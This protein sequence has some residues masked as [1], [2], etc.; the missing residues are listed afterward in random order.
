MPHPCFC[1]EAKAEFRAETC[2][3][4]KLPLPRTI[5]SHPCTPA[6]VAR[7]SHSSEPGV[8]DGS[9]VCQSSAEAFALS[10]VSTNDP[11]EFAVVVSRSQEDK[12]LG[13]SIRQTSG[14]LTVLSVGPGLVDQWNRTHPDCCVEPGDVLVEV[15]GLRGV[16]GDML[17]VRACSA[18][19]IT[20]I[21]DKRFR[22]SPM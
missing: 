17:M 20:L 10:D 18:D 12:K 3:E 2:E 4:R 5:S 9:S 15:N 16:P 13:V 22:S 14:R 11:I 6:D 7:G 19:I 8:L 21:F 1:C